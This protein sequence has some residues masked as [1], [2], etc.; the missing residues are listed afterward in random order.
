MQASIDSNLAGWPLTFW[1]KLLR[2]PY[3][4]GKSYQEA[5]IDW[6]KKD[7]KMTGKAAKKPLLVKEKLP[8][9]IYR[10]GKLPRC[11]KSCQEAPI[12]WGKA[13]KK[14]AKMPW[15]A[16]KKPLLVREKMPRS[17]EKLPRSPEMLSRSPFWSGKSC[18]ESPIGWGKAAKKA[19]K[20]PWKAGYYFT[21]Q[22]N[23]II[24]IAKYIS[25]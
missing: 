23:N 7:A 25:Q 4:S 11:L 3:Y 14:A 9:S 10:S 18:Q 6:E 2:S 16:A 8:R 19:A 1:K 21:A 20:L 5:S 17:L 13:A 12:G 22:T 24:T 15:K